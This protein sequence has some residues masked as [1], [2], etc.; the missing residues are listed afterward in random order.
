MPRGDKTGPE[1]KGPKTGRGL[2][3]CSDK[4]VKEIEKETSD[5]YNNVVGR[6]GG[7]RFGPG[8]GTGNRPRRK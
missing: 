5:I 6:R 7:R 2:G 8:D 4:D 3:K 1:G